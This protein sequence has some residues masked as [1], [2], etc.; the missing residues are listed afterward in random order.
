MET[1]LDIKNALKDIPDDVLHEVWFGLGEGAEEEIGVIASETGTYSEKQIGWP[2]VFE[3]YPQLGEIDKFI[4]NIIKAESK[5]SEDD[6]LSQ[7][8][9]GGERISSETK[10]E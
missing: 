8:L 1:L 7:D 4:R 3:K 9:F 2:E 6:N 5:I 10:F